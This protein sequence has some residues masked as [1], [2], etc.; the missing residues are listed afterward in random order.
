MQP[1]K[2]FGLAAVAAAG[3]LGLVWG[4]WTVLDR[5]TESERVANPPDLKRVVDTIAESGREIAG[6]D[7]RNRSDRDDRDAGLGSE[8]AEDDGAVDDTI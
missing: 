3:A 8:N 5:A 6:R 7:S 2:V 4:A 1:A